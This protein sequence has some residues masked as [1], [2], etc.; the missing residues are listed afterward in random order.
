M[1]AAFL[2]IMRDIGFPI[3]AVVVAYGTWRVSTLFQALGTTMSDRFNSLISK[4]SENHV[5]AEKRLALLERAVER[6]DRIV[7][8]HDEDL[9]KR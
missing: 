3:W 9:R 4:I 8:R 7:E 5:E 2:S 6:L 1:E